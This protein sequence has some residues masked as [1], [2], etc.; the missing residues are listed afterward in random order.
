MGSLNQLT[1]ICD[2]ASEHGEM[3]DHLL[4]FVNW[5]MLILFVGWRIFIGMAI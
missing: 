4:E 1:G 2:L 5:F 3:V